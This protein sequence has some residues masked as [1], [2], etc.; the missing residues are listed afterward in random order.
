MLHHFAI[1]RVLLCQHDKNKQ[2]VTDRHCSFIPSLTTDNQQP[3]TNN[4]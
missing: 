4:R 3:T 2:L 1:A